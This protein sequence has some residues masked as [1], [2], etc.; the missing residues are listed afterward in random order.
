MFRPFF[1]VVFAKLRG[2]LTSNIIVVRLFPLLGT[3][4]NT[5]Q[6]AISYTLPVPA[7]IPHAGST[8]LT[9]FDLRLLCVAILLKRYYSDRPVSEIL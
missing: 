9:E 7:L 1:K 3:S 4:L 6:A 8:T 5:L 2:F